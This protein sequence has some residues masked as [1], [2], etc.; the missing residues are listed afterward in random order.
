MIR[1]QD[2]LKEYFASKVS[3]DPDTGIFVN[4]L[5]SCGRKEGVI[6]LV[7][8]DGKSPRVSLDY[9]FYQASHIALLLTFNRKVGRYEQVTYIDGN[10]TNLRINNLKIVPTQ[11]LKQSST[12]I[13][14]VHKRGKYF[15]ANIS[16]DGE[17]ISHRYDTKQAAIK[18]RIKW[19]AQL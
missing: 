10:R 14:G 12:K 8:Y 13:R 19:E 7:S 4:L 11:L 2:T 15:I 5:G 3:Y 18:Q 1:N 17:L 9:C 16:M 6:K